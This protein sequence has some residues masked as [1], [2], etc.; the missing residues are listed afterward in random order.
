MQKRHG[1]KIILLNLLL[2]LKKQ[3]TSH[4][5]IFQRIRISPFFTQF[6]ITSI[7]TFTKNNNSQY[8]LSHDVYLFNEGLNNA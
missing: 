1:L 2:D 7:S 6:H 5:Q 3:L 4:F 8:K